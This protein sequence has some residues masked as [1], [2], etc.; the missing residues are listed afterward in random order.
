M[1]KIQDLL[2]KL[3][4]TTI[5]NAIAELDIFGEKAKF[6]KELAIYIRDRES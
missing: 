1:Q 5:N 2:S 3:R 4:M 6:L